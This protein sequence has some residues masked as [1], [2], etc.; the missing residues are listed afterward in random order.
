MFIL[1]FGKSW[2]GIWAPIVL[3]IFALLHVSPLQLGVHWRSFRRFIPGTS[4]ASAACSILKFGP[5]F[6]FCLGQAWGPFVLEVMGV[7]L[8]GQPLWVGCLSSYA[9]QLSSAKV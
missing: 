1:C 9:H 7:S 3:Q 5:C 8:S 2:W 6:R 4:L